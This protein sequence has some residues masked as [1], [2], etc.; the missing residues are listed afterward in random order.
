MI[1]S[2]N[3]PFLRVT[4]DQ[5]APVELVQGSSRPDETRQVPVRRRFDK[6]FV[7]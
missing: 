4:A 6:E 7:Y 2:D 3:H 5:L 1:A